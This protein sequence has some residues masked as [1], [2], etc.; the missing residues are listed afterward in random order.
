MA[1]LITRGERSGVSVTDYRDLMKTMR[2]INPALVRQ[3]RKDFRLIAK[4]IQTGVSKAIPKK[5]PTSGI[6]ISDPKR[7]VSGFKPVVV[8]GRLTWSANPQNGGKKPTHT[9]VKLPRVRNKFKN[10]AT[11][12]SIARVEVDN[13]AVVMADMAGKSGKWINKKEVTRPYLYSRSATSTGKHGT[14]QKLISMRQHRINGQGRGMIQALN[15]VHKPSRWI[16]PAAEQELPRI[17][18]QAVGVLAKAYS[19]IN[20]KLRTK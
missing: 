4:P 10:G 2:Q 18:L 20:N 5:P 9:L 11:V 13:A 7:T 3:M 17:R 1:Q 8:P 16:Y 15:K 6:H 19:E 12:S 14:K